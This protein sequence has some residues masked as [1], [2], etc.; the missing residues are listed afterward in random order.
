MTDAQY[1]ATLPKVSLFKLGDRYYWTE[2]LYK[3]YASEKNALKDVQPVEIADDGQGMTVT[4]HGKV[5][6]VSNNKI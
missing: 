2:N 5:Y 6:S 1:L 4:I 3:S